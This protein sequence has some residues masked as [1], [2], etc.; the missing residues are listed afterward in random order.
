MHTR[1]HSFSWTVTDR[2]KFQSTCV[3]LRRHS[4]CAIKVLKKAK[5]WGDFFCIFAIKLGIHRISQFLLIVYW[6]LYLLSIRF[7]L[8]FIFISPPLSFTSQ[9]SRVISYFF[10]ESSYISRMLHKYST[11]FKRFYLVHGKRFNLH[12]C[13]FF[14]G[15]A[16]EKVL[17]I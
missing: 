10:I 4:K 12:F 17:T 15:V 5:L 7:L 11:A 3:L 6:T 16:K 8:K 2:C 13:F 1:I 9:T 14:F